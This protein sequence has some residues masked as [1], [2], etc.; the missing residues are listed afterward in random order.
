MVKC[1]LVVVKS[2][3]SGTL[4]LDLVVVKFLVQKNISHKSKPSSFHQNTGKLSIIAQRLYEAK[5]SLGGNHQR[6]LM[7]A[8][9]SGGLS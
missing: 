4:S 8:E 5:M 1:P 2:L 7:L 9:K 3:L 6:H